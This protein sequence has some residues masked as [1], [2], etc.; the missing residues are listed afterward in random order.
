MFDYAFQLQKL[1]VI[2]YTLYVDRVFF[3][4]IERRGG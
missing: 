4:K 2:Y 1:I 3:I